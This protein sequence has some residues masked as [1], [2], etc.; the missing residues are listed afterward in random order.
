MDSAPG[1]DGQRWTRASDAAAFLQ[2]TDPR[3][4]QRRFTTTDDPRVVHQV[5]PALETRPG[6]RPKY[7]V[8]A[9]EVLAEGA[10]AGIRPAPSPAQRANQTLSSVGADRASEYSRVEVQDLPT[11]P[12]A[13]QIEALR[14]A[15]GFSLEH[16]ERLLQQL[17]AAYQTAI[18][19]VENELLLLDE[20]R[21]F[22]TPP[23]PP[24]ESES[25]PSTE[26]PNDQ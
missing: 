13:S 22:E 25:G 1:P 6:A 10:R 23:F 17:R 2:W 21:Q 15:R 7:L 14:S 18:T 26:T 3:K 11:S 20:M 5:L 9:E 8:L 16:R 19:H 4:V 24:A 12:D